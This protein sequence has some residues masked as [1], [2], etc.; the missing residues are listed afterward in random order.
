MEG[1]PALTVHCPG[2][3]HVHVKKGQRLP[4]GLKTP[5]AVER[6]SRV[7]IGGKEVYVLCFKQ[8]RPF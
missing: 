6:R 5:W 7:A 3:P 1:G 4:A 8:A 2:Q